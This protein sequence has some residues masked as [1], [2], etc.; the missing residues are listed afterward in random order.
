MPTTTFKDQWAPKSASTSQLD[1][2]LSVSPGYFITE[3]GQKL[4]VH[5]LFMRWLL[6]LVDAG[7][8]EDF[9]RTGVRRYLK[10]HSTIF[11]YLFC[12]VTPTQSSSLST[13]THRSAG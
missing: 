11:P 1:Q 8:R 5:N 4:G 7:M 13:L 12:I 9:M 6:S 2:T 10:S 3:W